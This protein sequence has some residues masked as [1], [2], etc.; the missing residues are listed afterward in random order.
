[1]VMTLTTE[2]SK[3]LGPI[4]PKQFQAALDH[5]DLGQF[6]RAEPIPF[7]NFGQ[8]VFVSSTTG[9]FVLRGAAHYVWQFP[10]EQFVA[11]SLHEQTSVPV[12]W[13]YLLDTDESIFGWKYGYVIMPRMPGLQLADTQV[14]KT[15]ESADRIK[16]AY[17]LGENLREIQRAT[18]QTSGRYDLETKTIKPFNGGFTT[19]IVDETK[20]WLQKSAGA[21]QADKEWVEQVI[22]S[23][24]EV[25]SEPLTPVLVLQDYKEANLTVEKDHNDWRVSGVFDL[26][27]A[28]FGDGELDLARQLSAYLEEDMELAKAFLNG[29]QKDTPLRPGAK[30]R[31]AL[32]ITYDRLIVWEYFHRPEQLSMWWYHAKSIQEWVGSYLA[33]L[34]TLMPGTQE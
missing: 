22:N 26:M 7:G 1:M 15:I 12:P 3:R 20:Q 31:L 19:W 27:E 5:F 28:L 33:K 9:E 29:Y 18:W 24:K 11:R 6:I 34:E 17:T 16:I 25:L 2:Y 4:S 23:A 32:Y 10:D 21:T 13:P 8:N 14:L 30:D